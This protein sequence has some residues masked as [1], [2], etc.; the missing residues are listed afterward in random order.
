M[1]LAR[2]SGDDVASDGAIVEGEQRLGAARRRR[3]AR[4]TTSSAAAPAS[5]LVEA[6]RRAGGARGAGAGATRA[7]GRG[8]AAA[9]RCGASTATCC[10]PA[11][12]TGTTSRS[13]AGKREGQDVERPRAPDLL[14]QGPRHGH[15]PVRRHRVRPGSCRPKWDYEAEVA[16]VIGSDGRSHPRGRR[17]WSTSSATASPTTSRSATCSGRTAASG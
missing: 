7:A 13:R 6:D 8:A 4:S 3:W 2:T 11:G 10:A 1:R 15:R 12:T 17:R 16:L 5:A 9:R 14:H